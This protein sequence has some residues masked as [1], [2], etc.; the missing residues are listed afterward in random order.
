VTGFGEN[1][2]TAMT[3]ALSLPLP[4]FDRNRGQHRRRARRTSGR[5]GAR[6]AGASGRRSR[7]GRRGRAPGA[8]RP[9]ASRP[10]TR[11]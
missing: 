7:P 3:F 1:D 4:L 11:A 9:A 2:E 6:H 5:R 8:L 10:P